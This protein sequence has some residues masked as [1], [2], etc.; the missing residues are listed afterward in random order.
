MWNWNSKICFNISFSLRINH[1]NVELKFE[2]YPLRIC[3]ISGLIIP[4]WNWNKSKCCLFVHVI[5]GLII[6]MWNWNILYRRYKSPVLRI[7]HTNVELKFTISPPCHSVF[8]GLII[9]MWNWN[10]LTSAIAS[11]VAGINHT[12][13]ELKSLTCFK[14]GYEFGQGLIIPM[15]N[16]NTFNFSIFT[17]PNKRINHTN[18]ELKCQLNPITVQMY[19]IGLIIP[20]WNWNCVNNLYIFCSVGGD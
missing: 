11:C 10:V 3:T 2:L 15:W 7:N 9:P 5:F 20:M 13:V 8:Q 18:V 4:M 14:S 1:T 16:W 12:N 6:P 17:K 19:I